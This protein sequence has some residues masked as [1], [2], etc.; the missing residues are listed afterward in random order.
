MQAEEGEEDDPA[1]SAP[2]PG[3]PGGIPLSGN[4]LALPRPGTPRSAGGLDD[5][6]PRRST[7]SVA[8]TPAAHR[9]GTHRTTFGGDEPTLCFVVPNIDAFEAAWSLPRED[10]RFYV[11]LHEVV[12][13]AVRSVPWVRE[14]PRAPLDRVRVELRDRPGR[15]RDRSSATSTRPTPSRSSASPATPQRILGA[16]QSQRQ[17]A[18][19]EELQRLTSVTDGYADFVLETIGRRLISHVRS[20]PRGDE[21]PPRRARAKP[22]GSS[23]ACSASSSNAADYER[24]RGVLPRRRRA[25]RAP[26]AS[27]GCGSARRCCRPRPSSTPPG[28]GSPA[29]TCS[30]ALPERR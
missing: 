20:D 19:R 17:Q 13:A 2:L 26:T 9:P 28:S 24:G 14:P 23:K 12:H 6:V 8:T 7:P 29:S 21:A 22:S 18:P 25:R 27:T 15:V 5:R 4:M 30:R 3:F 10:L 1:V 16:M 11:A